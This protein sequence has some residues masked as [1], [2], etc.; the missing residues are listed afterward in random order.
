M[1][2][3]LPCNLCLCYPVVFVSRKREYNTNHLIKLVYSVECKTC[4]AS[5][6]VDATGETTPGDGA[7]DAI[8]I[9]NDTWGVHQ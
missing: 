3:P 2:T 8:N 1:N 7:N 4:G 6:Y 9:W 5:T